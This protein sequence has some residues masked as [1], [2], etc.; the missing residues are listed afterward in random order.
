[1]LPINAFSIHELVAF[2]LVTPLALIFYVTYFFL[3]RHRVDLLLANWLACLAA[4]CLF[5]LLEDNVVPA[6]VSVW[7]VPNAATVTLKWFRLNFVVGLLVLVTQFHFVLCYCQSRYAGGIYMGCAYLACLLAAP[8]IFTPL[9]VSERAEPL[10][11][12]SSWNNSLPWMPEAT[13]LMFGYTCLWNAGWIAPVVLLWQHRRRRLSQAGEGA[14]SMVSLVL[15]AFVILGVAAG[16]D[17][18]MTVTGYTGPATNPGAVIIMAGMITIALARERQVADRHQKGL[19]TELGIARQIQSDLLPKTQTG[20]SGFEWAGWS[21][22]ARAAGGDYYDLFRMADGRWLLAM[23]D[24]SG[25]G[26][27][28]ALIVNET[29]A[30]LRAL[31]VRCQDAGTI[32]M[33]AQGLL[34][35]DLPANHFVTC[36]VGVLDPSS[37]TLSYASA[38]QGPI[39]F[40]KRSAGRFDEEPATCLPLMSS[41]ALNRDCQVRQRRF[42]AGDLLVLVSDGFLEA[43]DATHKPF[44]NDRLL[45]VLRGSLHLPPAQVIDCVC[46]EVEQFVGTA[47][48][49]DD[50]TIIIMRKCPATRGCTQL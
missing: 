26:L 16:A 32:L 33:S 21:R 43:P 37:A 7:A 42:E 29:R 23:A 25:H 3:G 10:G 48:Q 9:F 39:I 28:P 41:E 18:V 31:S 38:G 6:G 24:V 14:A 2:I 13:P 1:M 5:Y 47:E 15:A 20:P 4:G 50:M 46:R 19:E 40:Y 35:T 34:V 45:E 30:L 22:P 8:L 17:L 27:G 11:E 36:F 12:T 44:G 49:R